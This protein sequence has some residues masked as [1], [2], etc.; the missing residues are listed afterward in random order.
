MKQKNKCKSADNRITS[1]PWYK[2]FSAFVQLR[3]LQPRTRKAY[4]SWVRRLAEH[5][6][7]KSIRRLGETKVRDFLLHLKVERELKDSTINQA[8]CALRAFYRDHLGREWKCWQ[9]IKFHREELLPNIISREEACP[10]PVEGMATLLGSI[11]QGRFRALFTVMHH[12]GLRLSECTHLKPGHIDGKR[13]VLRVV[14]GKG[15]KSREVPISE[16]LLVRLRRYYRAHRNPEW[17]FPGVGQGWNPQRCSLAEAMHRARSHISTSSVQNAL[18]A[19]VLALGW[20]AKG[21]RRPITCH[22][23]RH[24]YHSCNHRNCPV[25]GALD[26][27][28]WCATQEA[29]LLPGVPYFLITFTVPESLRPLC[30]Q[31]PK[32]LYDL[33]LREVP[34]ATLQDIARTKLRGRLGFTAVLHTWGRQMQRP[35]RDRHLPGSLPHPC[36]AQGLRAGAPLRMD[37]RRGPQDPPPHPLSG[38]RRDRR[39]LS[40]T[41]RD[42]H[43]LLSRLR[44]GHDPPRHPRPPQL[45]TRTASITMSFQIDQSSPARLRSSPGGSFVVIFL[46]SPPNRLLTRSSAPDTPSSP[47]SRDPRPAPSA[48]ASLPPPL[49]LLPTASLPLPL[50]ATH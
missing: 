26:Q 11:G 22:T 40:Q 44:R 12:C 47:A 48:N 3:D 18:K 21:G 34:A 6:Q 37:G 45:Q 33:L 17:L 5:Y 1:E 39:T 49:R 30:K 28:R 10:E 29:R 16:E 50:F 13:R 14:N 4:L 43:A 36:P 46:Q 23:L 15:G 24:C 35:P 7:C 27:Q 20:E 38:L 19:V 2:E 41:P 42:A 25:C 9:A 31:H 32:V 8:L